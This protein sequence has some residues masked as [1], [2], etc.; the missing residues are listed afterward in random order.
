MLDFALEVMAMKGKIRRF[1]NDC[2]EL[3]SVSVDVHGLSPPLQVGSKFEV[4]VPRGDGIPNSMG[5][6]CLDLEGSR[7]ET[8]YPFGIE[9]SMTSPEI[10]G[11]ELFYP[12]T[13][14]EMD[15]GCMRPDN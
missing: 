6:S 10:R 2:S 4:S 5:V 8:E 9:I 7:L 3:P 15:C 12:C 11:P 13:V 1:Y 14:I